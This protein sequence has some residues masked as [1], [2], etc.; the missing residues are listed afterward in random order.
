MGETDIHFLIIGFWA[1]PLAE[2]KQQI[3]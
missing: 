3:T 2:M 1:R